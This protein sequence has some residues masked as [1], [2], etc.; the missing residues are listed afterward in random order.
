VTGTCRLEIVDGTG[1]KLWERRSDAEQ[2]QERLTVQ[3][4]MNRVRWE[5][6][7]DDAKGFDGMILWSGGLSGPRKP[8]PGSYRVRLQFDEQ[9]SE[10]ALVVRKDPRSPASEAELQAAFGF[11]IECR[12]AI[13]A[14]HEA[15]IAIRSMHKQIDAVVAVADGDG[16]QRLQ[17]AGDA[18][19]AALGVVEEALYQ[20]QSKSSQDPL[21]YPIKL[22]DKLAG[23]M[24]AVNGAEFGPTGAQTAVKDEL[25]AAI[26]AELAK[27]EAAKAD[28]VAKFNALARE[29]AVPHVR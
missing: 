28:A 23:V 26:R 29:L 17:A 13:T 2:E 25:L 14:A 20:T 18:A 11:V 7:F 19:K 16:K 8:A 3:R 4:G 9:A 22:T 10:A 1:K 27:F 5:P 15:I 6:K 21:N 12:D 24:G